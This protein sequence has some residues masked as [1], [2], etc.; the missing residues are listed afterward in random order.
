MPEEP[1]LRSDWL[2]SLI[3]LLVF[4]SGIGLLIATFN[5]AFSLFSVPPSVALT[6]AETKAVDLARAGETL[7]SIVI[8]MLLLL[9]MCVVGSVVAN[10]GIRLYVSCRVP[11]PPK[12]PAGEPAA[13]GVP[14]KSSA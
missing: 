1:K 14:E 7:G 3:G 8:K 5:L 12:E 11:P 4:L 6:D 13:S 9:V 2:G 10:R